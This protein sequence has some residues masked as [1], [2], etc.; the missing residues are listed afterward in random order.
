MRPTNTRQAALQTRDLLVRSLPGSRRG[1]VRA[2]LARAELIGATIYRRFQVGPYQTQAKH[3]RWYLETQTLNLTP[4]TRYRHWLTIRAIIS[5]FDKQESW[6][7][8][9]N[10]SWIRPDGKTGPL[11]PGRPSKAAGMWK[12]IET[13][14]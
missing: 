14:N 4:S 5:A 11:K 13:P 2:H 6:M 12:R 1:T 3:Y 7:P 8:L 9:L 10:G